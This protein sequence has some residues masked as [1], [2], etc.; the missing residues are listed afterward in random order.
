MDFEWF[1]MFLLV[2]GVVWV[3]WLIFKQKM[4]SEGLGKL[5]SYFA[6]VVVTLVAVWLIVTRVF[7]WWAN[8]MLTDA[9]NSQSA[10]T[11]ESAIQDVLD[12]VVS[13]NNQPAVTAVPST[14]S[15]TQEPVVQPTQE[16]QGSVSGQSVGAG[17]TVHIVQSGDT[18]Y[19]LGK[20]YGV[21]VQAIQQRNDLSGITINIGQ[22]LVIPAP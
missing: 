1:A 18:L 3:L 16:G 5:V 22:E 10:Q 9:Q 15:A 6:G 7:P 20:K 21:S 14:T 12:G 8:K 4:L 11:V 13:N 2:L 17:E 19:S